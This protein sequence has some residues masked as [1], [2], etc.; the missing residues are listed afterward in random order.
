[1]TLWDGIIENLSFSEGLIPLIAQD[2]FSGRVLMLGYAS[3]ESLEKTKEE[4]Y[5]WFYSR[6]RKKLWKKG[7]TSKNTL[8]VISL[9]KDCDNDTLIAFVEPSGPTC[10]LGYE[11]CFNIQKQFGFFNK[12]ES[13][14]DKRVQEETQEKSY[15]KRLFEKGLGRMAQKVGEEAAEVMVASFENKNIIEESADL[16][17]HLLVLLRFKNLNLADVFDELEKR[18]QEKSSPETQSKL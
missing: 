5:L 16:I 8:K 10:H 4:G 7:E 6:S 1:M 18:H 3:K 12:L 17:Y 13:V 14:I 15:T 2:V 9:W 11:N